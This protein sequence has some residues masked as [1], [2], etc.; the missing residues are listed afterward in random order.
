MKNTIKTATAIL[1]VFV[2]IAILTNEFT[3][4]AL[5]DS[6][7]TSLKELALALAWQSYKIGCNLDKTIPLGSY[8]PKTKQTNNYYETEVKQQAKVEKRR[9]TRSEQMLINSID[10]HEVCHKR[11]FETEHRLN[12][13]LLYP[14]ILRNEF[15]CY[16]EQFNYLEENKLSVSIK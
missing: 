16:I 3:T 6:T 7:N 10:I 2:V 4:K 14:M 15:E 5:L 9:I 13:C 8:N 11:Q 1:V 12:S